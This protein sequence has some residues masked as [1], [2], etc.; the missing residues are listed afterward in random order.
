MKVELANMTNYA[1]IY[2]VC[3]ESGKVIGT[4]EQRLAGR[5]VGT[6]CYTWSGKYPKRDIRKFWN[7][8][9]K[10]NKNV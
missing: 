3:D 8:Y 5:D 4:V 6:Y 1:N 2:R 7:E 9:R 10:E